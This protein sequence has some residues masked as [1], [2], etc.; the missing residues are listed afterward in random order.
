[1]HLETMLAKNKAD[2][3]EVESAP[4]PLP[5]RRMPPAYGQGY[6]GIAGDDEGETLRYQVTTTDLSLLTAKAARARVQWMHDVVSPAASYNLGTGDL[7]MLGF[8]PQRRLLGD[9]A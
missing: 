2:L 5:R 8:V 6:V 3:A 9:L 1:M 7:A 4:A